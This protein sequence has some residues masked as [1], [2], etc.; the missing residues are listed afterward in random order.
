MIGR[1][2]QSLRGLLAVAAASGLACSFGAGAAL[3]QS[4]LDNSNTNLVQNGGFESGSGSSIPDWTVQWDNSVD[5]FVYIETSHPHSGSQDLAIGT[6]PAP[7]DIIQQIKGT[8]TGQVY[9]ICFWL[10]SA[11]NP[12]AGV[13]TFE[14]AWN[15]V[16]QLSLINS[17]SFDYQ[18]YAINVVAQGNNQDYLQ[19]R[20]RNKQGFYYIDD[21]AVQECSGCGLARKAKSKG[22]N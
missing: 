3:A 18:Y 16:T 5:P 2:P 11:P 1:H 22:K 4:C 8:T 13:T 15:N 20:E 7:N 6:V 19:L 14:V 21:V 9:T 12:S 10:Y 17:G